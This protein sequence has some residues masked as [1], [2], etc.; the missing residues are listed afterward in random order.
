MFGFISGIYVG[1][2][3]D[4]KPMLENLTDYIRKNIPK[5]NREK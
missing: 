3:Y 2:Y 5:E 4:C 1:T